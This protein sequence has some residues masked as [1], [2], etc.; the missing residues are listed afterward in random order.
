MIP[1]VIYVVCFSVPYGVNADSFK[2]SRA[3]AV[4]DAG[5]KEV[6]EGSEKD[7]KKRVVLWGED[8][9]FVTA[10]YGYI[11]YTSDWFEI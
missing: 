1:L 9:S 10:I 5:K 7:S 4:E 2:L 3:V 8:N 6:K 11:T